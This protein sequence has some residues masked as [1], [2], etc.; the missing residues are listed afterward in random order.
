MRPE[1]SPSCCASPGAANTSQAA[2][3]A[4]SARFIM[5]TQSWADRQLWP[6]DQPQQGQQGALWVDFWVHLAVRAN[7]CSLVHTVWGRVGNQDVESE[8]TC[9]PPLPAATLPATDAHVTAQHC[10]PRRQGCLEG[11]CIQTM[12]QSSQATRL[13]AV[14]ISVGG[15]ALLYNR[16]VVAHC[17]EGHAQAQP[18]PGRRFLTRPRQRQSGVG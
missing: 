12:K 3:Q 7:E 18:S 8:Q 9:A 15:S 1:S 10:S 5:C 2:S 14:E 11:W 17:A 4:S 16:A 6:T 13:A